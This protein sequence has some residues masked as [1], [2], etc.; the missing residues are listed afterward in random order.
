MR[1]GIKNNVY[2]MSHREYK[3]FLNIASK[4]LPIGI[5]A[6]EKGNIAVM[7][8]EKYENTNDLKQ[9]I[10]EYQMKGFKVYYNAK[11]KK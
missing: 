1:V 4:S 8:N 5:Y 9:A 11:S 7:T 10:A 6:V 3:K 2:G